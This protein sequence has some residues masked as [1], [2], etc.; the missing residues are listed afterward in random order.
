MDRTVLCIDGGGTKTAGLVADVHGA[1]HTLTPA[2]GCNPQ[3][4]LGWQNALG[5]LFDQAPG[6]DFAVIGMPGFGEVP[7][8][9]TEAVNFIKTKISADHLII[10]DVELAFRGAFPDRNGVLVLAGTGSMAIGQAGGD[11]RRSGG[12]GHWLGDEG[13]AFWIG[14]QA[15][16]RAA[17]EL[18]GRTPHVGFA[19][20]LA[21]ALDAPNHPFGLLDWAMQDGSSRARIASV[22]R[23]V[24]DLSLSGDVT[25]RSILGAAACHLTALAQSVLHTSQPWA[26]AGS[27]F[28]STHITDAMTQSLGP[29]KPPATSALV[30]GV[31]HA[32]TLA[33]WDTSPAWTDK[34][35]SQGTHL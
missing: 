10:N 26:H 12:W 25:A 8:H 6:I 33:G 23:T 2:E 4:R 17:A 30:G 11:I 32:A 15:L 28:Q 31:L 16:S 34:V 24:D 14:Q 13:S 3:D 19:A 29:A 18:D 5:S 7:K 20:K 1:L 21:D 27:V 35:M 22:A 9:D